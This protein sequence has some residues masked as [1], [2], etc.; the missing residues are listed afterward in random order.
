MRFRSIQ[1]VNPNYF[2]NDQVL[3]KSRN[4]YEIQVNTK[5]LLNTQRDMISLLLLS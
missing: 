3:D 5:M 4:P 1:S 2:L